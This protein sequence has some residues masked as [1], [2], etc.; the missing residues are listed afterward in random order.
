MSQY[1]RF[2]QHLFENQ[3]PDMIA[4]M[5]NSVPSHTY[6]N[7]W[8]TWHMDKPVSRIAVPRAL[9]YNCV[10]D[11]ESC[12]YT[13]RE[14]EDFNNV[15]FFLYISRFPELCEMTANCESAVDG[16]LFGFDNRD[17]A[18]FIERGGGTIS[19]PE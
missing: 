5:R 1:V 2:G 7:I 13:H 10:D 8:E 18:S 11:I 3:L 9:P 19:S 14:G 12:F 6:Q 4:D 16:I 17:V 15:D